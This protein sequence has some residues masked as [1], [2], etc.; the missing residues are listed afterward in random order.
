[1]ATPA[2]TPLDAPPAPGVAQP[3]SLATLPEKEDAGDADKRVQVLEFMQRAAESGELMA[4]LQD[5]Q[6]AE[7]PAPAAATAS[8]GESQKFA[9]KAESM[10][11]PPPQPA[12]P[13]AEDLPVTSLAAATA[14]EPAAIVTA[15]PAA[16]VSAN[17]P[18]GQQ[19]TSKKPAPA[20]LTFQAISQK[21][22]R[23]AELEEMIKYTERQIALREKSCKD[24]EKTI[25]AVK[26]DL[27]QLELDIEWNKRAFASAE[28]KR[29]ELEANQRKLLLDITQPGF[30][31]MDEDAGTTNFHTSR[32][33]MST[34]TGGATVTS[35]GSTQPPC[36]NL[37]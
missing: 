24:M 33:E 31:H 34:T 27:S 6:A 20:M 10:A 3:S 19:P 28:D 9:N 37:S 22:R 26:L 4:A 1:M 12:E 18:E 8:E 30:K 17:L 16:V 15:E 2:N 11:P 25:A 32:S 23:A 36:T 5:L 7:P 14:E 13:P 35:V 21:T 29:R